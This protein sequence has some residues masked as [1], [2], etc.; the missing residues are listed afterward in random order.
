M[1]EFE[2]NFI[3]VAE[4]GGYLVFTMNE[5]D[6]DCASMD[7]ISQR[8]EIVSQQLSVMKCRKATVY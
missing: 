3:Q 1:L 8:L 5:Q 7:M 2:W 4:K 6:L